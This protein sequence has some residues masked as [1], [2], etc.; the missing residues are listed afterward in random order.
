MEGGKEGRREGRWTVMGERSD[1]ETEGERERWDGEMEG[2]RWKAECRMGGGVER[3]RRSGGSEERGE[4]D[5]GNKEERERGIWRGKGE[6]A[7]KRGTNGR[8]GKC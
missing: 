8:R 1:R 2:V 5:E 3:G 7:R 6:V 4:T